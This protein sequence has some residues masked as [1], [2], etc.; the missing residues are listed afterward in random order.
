MDYVYVV[1]DDGHPILFKKEED[2][3]KW[4][5]RLVNQV[6]ENKYYDV[7]DY[8]TEVSRI[9]D[10]EIHILLFR[11]IYKG[12]YEGTKAISYCKQQIL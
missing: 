2:A 3:R 9:D 12:R 10:D 5:M 4:W 1:N 6:K 7:E 8:S 11:A